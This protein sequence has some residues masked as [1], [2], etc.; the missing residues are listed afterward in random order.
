M[1]PRYTRERR[2]FLRGRYKCSEEISFV[3]NL[4]A[5]SQVDRIGLESQRCE[6]STSTRMFFHV[7]LFSLFVRNSMMS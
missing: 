5:A 1:L 4:R 7:S 2:E 6:V 3:K